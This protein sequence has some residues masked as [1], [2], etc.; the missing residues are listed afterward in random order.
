MAKQFSKETLEMISKAANQVMLEILNGN[1]ELTYHGD[2]YVGL[3][4]GDSK[5]SATIYKDG[6]ITMSVNQDKTN[7]ELR[8]DA[9]KKMKTEAIENEIKHLEESKEKLQT[10]L[11]ELNKKEEQS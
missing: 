8:K 5:I 11:D 6:S 7:A 2:T 3:C 9:F 1:T 10:E 4:T